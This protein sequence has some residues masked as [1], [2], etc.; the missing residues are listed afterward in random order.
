MV[1]V[2]R[3]RRLLLLAVRLILSA[4]VAQDKRLALS[5]LRIVWSRILRLKALGLHVARERIRHWRFFRL[6]GQRIIVFSKL[7]VRRDS[8]L[9]VEAVITNGIVGSFC[10]I[11]VRG[12][13]LL[14]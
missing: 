7:V 6:I 1:P 4:G 14:S 9:I 3:L 2:C 5:L 11:S 12:G 8:R 10:L 13:I